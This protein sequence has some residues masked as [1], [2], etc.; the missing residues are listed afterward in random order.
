[1]RATPAATPV[2]APVLVPTF[3]L[4]PVVVDHVPPGIAFVAVTVS[5]IHI[6]A[7]TP[8]MDG[9]IA[10]TVS[11]TVAAQ[12]V[13][14]DVYEMVATPPETPVATPPAEM[15]ATEALVLDQMQPVVALL[16]LVDA[17]SHMLRVPLTGM[18]E[19]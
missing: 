12:P 2:I 17:L 14:V 7:V 9:G 11:W 3:M 10:F 5:P 13:A 19:G 4:M 1:M 18:I 6:G 8:E 16:R 15:V